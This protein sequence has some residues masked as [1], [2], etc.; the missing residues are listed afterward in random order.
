MAKK[1]ESFFWTSYS[2]LMT[3]LFFV[4]LVLFVLSVKLLND[5][6][7]EIEEG[8]K[9]TEEQLNRIKTLNKS[10]ENI[11]RTYFVYNEKFKRHTMKNVKVNFQKGSAN[12][13]DISA[14]DKAKL[15]KMGAAI[16]KFMLNAQKDTLLKGAEYL[17]IVEG[18][19]SRD[20]QNRK[21]CNV[22]MNDVLSYERALALV[23]FWQENGYNF[24]HGSDKRCKL[25]CELII[26]GSGIDSPFREGISSNGIYTY[27][28]VKE[29][30]NQRFVIHIIPKPGNMLEKSDEIRN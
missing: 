17:L 2:D 21:W 1:K 22:N 26:S 19:A 30:S 15:L 8:K 13:D 16:Q 27:D 10:I 3:S 18:Q 9:A 11:D 7:R 25:P 29:I 28:R 24:G 23:N 20:A 5:K 12:I 6:I 4:M 14:S